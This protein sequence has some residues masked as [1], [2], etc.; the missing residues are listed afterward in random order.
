MNRKAMVVVDVGT[1][2]LRASFVDVNGQIIATERKVYARPYFSPRGGYCEQWPGFYY[3]TMCALLRA[4]VATPKA[5]GLEPAGLVVCGFRDTAALLGVDGEPVR[6]S[7]LWLDQRSARLPKDH[8]LRWYEKAL[9]WL[10]GMTDTVR[11]NARRTPAW[12]L[13]ENQPEIWSKVAKYVP[14]S[15]YWNKRLTGNLV[16]STADAVGHYPLNFRTGRWFRTG[17]PKVNVFGLAPSLL[18]PLVPCGQI[19]GT[20]TDRAAAETG[21]PAG[22]KV[23][24]SGSDKGCEVLGN[25]CNEESKA[26]VSYGTAC[27]IDV[28]SKR[29]IEPETFL[30]AYQSAAPGNFN[31]EVQVY[32]GFWMLKWFIANFAADKEAAEA[33]MRHMRI[34][35]LLDDKIKAIPAGSDGL[36]L[37]PYWGPGLKRPNARGAIVGFSDVHNKYHLYRATIEGIGYAL[38]DGLEEIQHHT[39]RRVKTL[40][41]SGGG[42]KSDIIAQ[43]TAD[44]FG[45][46]VLK[47]DT[48]ESSTVGGAIAGFVAAGVYK[49]ADEAIAHMVHYTKTFRPEPT[50][51]RQYDFLYRHAYRKIYPRLNRI[52]SDLK[53]FASQA[54]I[55]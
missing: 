25:G 20:I 26:T 53:G 1:Q 4:L 24:A 23:F 47:T 43:I 3:D 27:T 33:R 18:C 5:R 38:R 42:S 16:V 21:L 50:T 12:W 34:E 2:S 45:L 40:V 30:P 36:I 55:H 14:I 37:Q 54:E 48:T 41:V 9:F 6:S 51:C 15:A 35:A 32:R 31:L 11:F 52:Y 44:I 17:H 7:I 22:L 19:L 46:P 29:Y 10:I 28:F 8:N 49:T 39:H 13:K